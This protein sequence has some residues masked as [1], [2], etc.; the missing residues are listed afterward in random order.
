M[1]TEELE[2]RILRLITMRTDLRNMPT[3]LLTMAGSTRVLH[4]DTSFPR[5]APNLAESQHAQIRDMILSNLVSALLL[6]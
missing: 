2:K 5:M 3:V 4:E 1:K 6:K